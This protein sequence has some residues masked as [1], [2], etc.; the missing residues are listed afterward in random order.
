MSSRSR[1]PDDEQQF[2]RRTVDAAIRIGLLAALAVWC[3]DILRPVLVPMAWGIIIAVA[4]YPPYRRIETALGGRRGL[5]AVLVTLLML[6]VLVVPSSFLAGS[7]VKGAE[8]LAS[9]FQAGTL[10]VPPPPEHVAAWPLVG[11]DL[12]RFWRLASEDLQEALRQL[13]PLLKDA[14]GW[15]LRVAAGAGLGLLQFVVAI[16]IAGVLLARAAES[17]RAARAIAHRLSPEHG[18]GYTETAQKI[19]HSV[20]AGIVGVALLQG[21]L[22]GVGFLVAGVPAAGLL[23][24]LCIFL[25]VIQVGVAVVLIPVV[26][27]LFLTASTTTA[28]AF[29][30]YA[31]LIAPLDNILKP[32]LLGRGVRVPIVAVFI[33]AI[34]GFLSTGIIGL[35]VGA[36]GFSLGYSLLLAWLHR[37]NPPRPRAGA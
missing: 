2:L 10:T 16:L 15:L 12:Y 19:V 8:Q 23:T 5:A 4:V 30:V 1:L 28:V 22:A 31:I 18:L 27:W 17:G 9:A 33:G 26:V 3:F 13:S 7:M 36:V 25:G 37:D 14:G 35:F 6:A 21:L 29:L 24:L 32:I 11:K 20:A 34:G